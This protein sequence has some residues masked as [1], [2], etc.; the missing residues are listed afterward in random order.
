MDTRCLGGAIFLVLAKGVFK[1]VSEEK[2]AKSKSLIETIVKELETTGREEL[3]HK[4][5]EN[6]QGFF[7]I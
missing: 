1:T 4:Q 3:N 2:W 5:L 6:C 7:V